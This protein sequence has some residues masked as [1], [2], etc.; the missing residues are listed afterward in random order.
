MCMTFHLFQYYLEQNFFI[1]NII[2][3][4]VHVIFYAYIFEFIFDF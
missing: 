4:V 3:K 1:D 2:K